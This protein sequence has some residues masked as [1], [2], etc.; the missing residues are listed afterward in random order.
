MN[1]DAKIVFVGGGRG[2]G[3]STCLKELTEKNNRLITLDPVGD[4]AQEK[5]YTAFKTLKGL[6]R[7]LKQN[8]NKG[9]RCV[10]IVDRKDDPVQILEQLSEGLFVIQKPY[11]D[12]KDSRKITLIVEE[13]AITY[14]ERTLK[15]GERSFQQLI[16]LGRHYGV[17]IYGASQRMAEVK[18][19]FISNAADHY[20]FRMGAANDAKA[21][22]GLIGTEH[23]ATLAA[24]QTHEFLKF[25]QGQVTK[26][27]NKCN[28]NKRK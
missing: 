26:G 11:K 15:D 8:W 3:K 23:K 17:E 10:L 21:A 25:S 16:N 22:L 20:F 13:M 7:H 1:K 19:T 5:G 6:Y 12:C 18:K 24:L 9:F 28:F 27:K 2:S 4:Y 14:P